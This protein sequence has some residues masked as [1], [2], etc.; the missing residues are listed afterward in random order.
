MNSTVDQFIASFES[1]AEIATPTPIEENFL[2]D[3]KDVM[4]LAC[5]IGGR[6]DCVV[7]GDQDLLVIN[8]Y[9][10]VSIWTAGRLL[11]LLAA[12]EN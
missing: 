8:S 1:F 6:A 12:D 5:A 10:G 2:R 4:I 7:T 9:R 11:T 3:P